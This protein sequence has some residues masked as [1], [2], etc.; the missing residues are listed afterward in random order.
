MT[1]AFLFLTG[2]V[3]QRL[4]VRKSKPVT[5]MTE[6]GE[7]ANAGNLVIRLFGPL[8]AER[9][10]GPLPGLHRRAGYRLLAFL[11]LHHGEDV[12]YH[13][14]AERFFPAEARAVAEYGG[15]HGSTRQAIQALRTALGPD[16]YRLRSAGKGIVRLN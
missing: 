3:V 10:N 9:D 13:M 4:R 12:T 1:V 7:R 11:V 8:C 5:R 15:D 2:V 14:L 6:S 16:S